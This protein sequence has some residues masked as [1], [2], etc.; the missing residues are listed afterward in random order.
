MFDGGPVGLGTMMVL[1]AAESAEGSQPILPG[2]NAGGFYA[3][4]N[5]ARQVIRKGS[6]WRIDA[7]FRQRVA[8]PQLM[9]PSGVS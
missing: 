7:I 8:S 1:H 5:M 6:Q 3:L 9:N 2:V 4:L